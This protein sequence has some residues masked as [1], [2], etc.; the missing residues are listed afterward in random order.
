MSRPYHLLPMKRMGVDLCTA[1][2][3]LLASIGGCAQP[4]G[5]PD[6]LGRAATTQAPAAGPVYVGTGDPYSGGPL[7]VRQLNIP[8]CEQGSIVPLLILAPDAPGNYPVVVFQHGFV[9][10]NQAYRE[11]LSHLASH[12]FAVVAPQMYEPGLAALLGKPTAAEEAQRAAQV[13]DWLPAGLAATLGYAPAASRLGLAGHSRGAKVAWLVLAQDPSR[14]QAVAGVDPVD[15]RGGPRGNQ[16]RVVEGPFEFNLPALVIGTGLGG[17]CAPAGENHEQ[18]YA[19]SRPPAWHVVIPGAGHADMLDEASATAARAVCAGGP[20]RAAARRVTAGLL[21]A[22][23]RGS[24]QGDARAYA[25][26]TDDAGA[27]TT[28]EVES[29]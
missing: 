24:L 22:F 27:P 6:G 2:A 14:A 10:R 12:G 3:V 21:V 11:L 7:A 23:F 25:H 15:G 19:A 20:D 1:L 28:I 4:P 17:S 18:F 8:S 13:L 26:L 9:T 29:K 5:C 16:A